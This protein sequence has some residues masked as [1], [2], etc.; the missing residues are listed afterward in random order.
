M[1]ISDGRSKR[2]G[3]VIL[4]PKNTAVSY[5]NVYTSM[6]QPPI[7]R[8]PSYSPGHNYRGVALTPHPH[9]APSYLYSSSVPSLQVTG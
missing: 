2:F 9:L 8:I 7:Q 4:L 6:L 5:L 3:F 1:G